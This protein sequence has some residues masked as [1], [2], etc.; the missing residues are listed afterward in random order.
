M[1]NFS[2]YGY[3]GLLGRGRWGQRPMSRNATDQPLRKQT[4]LDPQKYP[5]RDGQYSRPGNT[6][7]IGIDA[8]FLFVRPTFSRTF[9]TASFSCEF[10]PTVSK[11]APRWVGNCRTLGQ[12]DFT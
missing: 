8:I 11:V 9:V 7:K 6:G 5:E 1:Q 12:L 2:R 10:H 3:R 4:I